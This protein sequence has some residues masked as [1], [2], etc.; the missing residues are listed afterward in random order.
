MEDEKKVYRPK[1]LTAED[2]KQGCVTLYGE[3]N[4]ETKLCMIQ[5][6]FRQGIDMIQSFNKSVTFYGS[7][8]LPES[9]PDYENAR[10]LAYRISKELG[11]A[12]LS[13]GGPGIMEAANRGA[14]EA[15]GKSVGLTI[16]LA[17]EQ[18]TNKYVTE[19]IPFY[20]FFARKVSMSYTTEACI[21]CAGGF[22]TFDELFEMLTL[23]QTR[24]IGEVPIILFGK[25]FWT[26]LQKIIEDIL[27]EKY[28]TV[29]RDELNLYTIT[30]DMNEVIDIIKKTKIRDGEDSLK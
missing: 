1:H 2:I 6:E 25:E 8:R 16:K 24:K 12:V 28:Q 22:G 29:N 7:A 21:F 13:G 4:E 19:E 17:R 15:G 9:H 27:V 23:R 5:E 20:F 30:D 14:Y 26:P 3:N 10:Q 18:N 11:Y